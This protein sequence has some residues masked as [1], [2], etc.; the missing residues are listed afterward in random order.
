MR[1]AQGCGPAICGAQVPETGTHSVTHKKG[2]PY[3]GDKFKSSG[4]DWHDH[5]HCLAPSQ[6][7]STRLNISKKHPIS[8]QSPSF[9]C[10]LKASSLEFNYL[11]TCPLFL[12]LCV[13]LQ[14]WVATRA[15]SSFQRGDAMRRSPP[16]P[17]RAHLPGPS[18]HCPAGIA[19]PAA[20]PKMAPIQWVQRGNE[21]GKISNFHSQ[22]LDVL[23]VQALISPFQTTSEH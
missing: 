13:S 1:R 12:K 10:T 18:T 2:G 17:R 6:M 14:Q 19:P 21:D 9:A 22:A 8:L 5:L 7:S 15:S 23:Q 3:R 11:N 20:I 16:I 4:L